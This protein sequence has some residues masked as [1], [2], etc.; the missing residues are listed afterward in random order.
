MA[1]N[2]RTMDKRLRLALLGTLLLVLLQAG[3]FLIVA[4]RNHGTDTAMLAFTFSFVSL[5]FIPTS[6]IL[7]GVVLYLV[8]HQHQE[9]KPLFLL[10]LVN[11]VLA[12][13]LAWFAV[14]PCSW[15]AIFGLRLAGC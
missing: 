2:L 14:H 10:G 11:V 9:Q 6:L 12:L 13:Q 5:F 4:E 15:A 8:R 3:E 1:I 7:T